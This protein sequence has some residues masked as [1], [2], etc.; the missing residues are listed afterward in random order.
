MSYRI[1]VEKRAEKDTAKIP[2]R[3]KVKIDNAIISLSSH[4][5]PHGCKNLTDR[6]GYRVRVGDYRILYTVDDKTRVVVVYR[7]KA[8]GKT[9]YK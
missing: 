9:T 5:R 7:I 1:L 2:T 4:P 8:R 3:Q 6:E